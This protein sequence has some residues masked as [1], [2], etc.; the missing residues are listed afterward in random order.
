MRNT[1]VNVMFNLL[2]LYLNTFICIFYATGYII[3]LA[4]TC[5]L[6]VLNYFKYFHYYNF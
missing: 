5:H 3:L 2:Y 6:S 4:H 1:Y